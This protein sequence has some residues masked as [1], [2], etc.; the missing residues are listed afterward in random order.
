MGSSI[1]RLG[2]PSHHTCVG[3]GMTANMGS[4]VS[5]GTF[6]PNLTGTVGCAQV[7]GGVEV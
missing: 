2:N 3:A 5:V 1:R 6:C 7:M 4:G